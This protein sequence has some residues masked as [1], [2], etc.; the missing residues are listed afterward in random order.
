MKTRI[1]IDSSLLSFVILLTGV[2]Y[3]VPRFYVG[4][5]AL[6]QVFDF[7][8]MIFILKGVFFRMVA[9]AHKKFHSQQG[10][11]LVSTGIYKY[12]RNPMYL[13]SFFIG[14]GFVLLVWPWW[15]Y[16]IFAALFYLR[17]RNEVNKEESLLSK[18]FGKNYEEYCQKTPRLF[19]LIQNFEKIKTREIFRFDEAFATSEARGLW[20]WPL[21]AFTLEIFQEKLVFG[22][23]DLKSTLLIFFWAAVTFTVLFWI[24]FQKS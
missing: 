1:K 5:K 8:G 17:F 22:F 3:L 14:S 4:S 21:L 6:D 13:G 2:L 9:R 7:F 19:P 11:E 15:S 10:G 20:G 16:P 23:I 24:Q 18:K 12:V